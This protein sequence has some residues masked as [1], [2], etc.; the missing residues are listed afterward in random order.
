[1]PRGGWGA[2]WLDRRFDTDADEFLDRDDVPAATR[3]RVIRGLDRFH[4]LTLTY[5]WLSRLVVASA[6]D[7][8]EPRIL[9]LGAGHGELSRRVLRRAPSAHVTVSDI[10]PGFVASLAASD[11]GTHP[12][13]DVRLI[14]A[15]AID[16]DDRSWDVAVFALSVHHLPPD[17]VTM[18]VAEMTRVARTVLLVD[19]WRNPILLATTP[20]FLLLGGR[21][22]FH[23]GVISLRRVYSRQAMHAMAAAAGGSI[24]VSAR[25]T[26][27]GYLVTT[28]RRLP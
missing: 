25:F 9:E 27:P 23:D 26:P 14:D 15:T 6:A 28:A 5:R 13:V 19:A 7:V 12:R 17:L 10:E 11:L 8:A 22:M 16:A 3:A 20:L 4:R 2:S 21:P 24:D 18:A 1:M